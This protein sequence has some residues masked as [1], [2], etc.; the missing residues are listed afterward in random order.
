MHEWTNEWISK[1][2][3]LET[4]TYR[5]STRT[6]GIN[7]KSVEL[8]QIAPV[9]HAR[10]LHSIHD[11]IQSFLEFTHLKYPPYRCC[12][13]HFFAI[14]YANSLIEV[15]IIL[16]LIKCRH[17]STYPT[18]SFTRTLLHHLCYTDN[19]SDPHTPWWQACK[20][21][22]NHINMQWQ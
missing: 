19:K 18:L 6:Y 10:P 13:F 11:P 21:V 7:M 14:L 1:D 5:K 15:S 20:Q 12:I 17:T 2:Q 8:Q 4:C 9:N 3:W 16:K 22:R